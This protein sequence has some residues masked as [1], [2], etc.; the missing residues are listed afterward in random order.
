MGLAVMVT[1]FDVDE[2]PSSFVYV[3]VKMPE[4]VTVILCVVAPLLHR[5]LVF[6][7][8][9]NVTLPPWQ[10]GLAPFIVITGLAGIVLGND[11]P[12]PAAP[13]HPFTV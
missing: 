2:Q 6:A 13:V 9:V 4:A 8:E 12:L 3:T 11:V 10:K 1:G 5:F 7:L